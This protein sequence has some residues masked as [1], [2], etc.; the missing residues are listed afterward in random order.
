MAARITYG[1]PAIGRDNDRV[2]CFDC[3]GK[4]HWIPPGSGIV[5][6]SPLAPIAALAKA[7]RRAPNSKRIRV[8]YDARANGDREGEDIANWDA[9]AL[10]PKFIALFDA[11]H[12]SPPCQSYSDLAKRN[13]SP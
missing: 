7:R 10:D 5:A 13:R 3:D 2:G 6:G 9:L 4:C 11:V 8:G 1:S 12:A